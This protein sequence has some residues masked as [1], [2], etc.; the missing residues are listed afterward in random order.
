MLENPNGMKNK[1][2]T[3]GSGTSIEKMGKSGKKVTHSSQNIL[4]KFAVFNLV[5]GE[6]SC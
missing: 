4:Q 2:N 1:T 5:Y 6:F 3:N